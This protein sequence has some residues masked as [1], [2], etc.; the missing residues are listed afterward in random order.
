MPLK[1]CITGQQLGTN[2]MYAQLENNPV[3][4]VRVQ[5]FPYILDNNTQNTFLQRAF[6]P[7]LGA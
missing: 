1:S 3:A 7:S 5:A 2:T 6:R 4:H